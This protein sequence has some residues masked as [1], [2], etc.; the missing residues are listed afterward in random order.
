MRTGLKQFFSYGYREFVMR[1]GLNA[2]ST[3]GA[4]NYMF[5]PGQLRFLMDCVTETAGIPGCY[6]EAGCAYGTTTAFLRK[7]MEESGIKKNYFA[8]DT[9]SGFPS[10][11]TEYEINV[12][13]KSADISF[14][15]S[16]NK[17]EWFDF[18]M[19][20]AGITDV[21]SVQVDIGNFDFDKIAPI[22]FCLLDVDL[23]L[24]IKDCLPRIFRNMPNGG[25]IVV[26][27]CIQDSLYD[28][29][30][31]AYAEFVESHNIT[32]QVVLGKLGFIRRQ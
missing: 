32:E 13:G 26:D 16:T 22:S 1:T 6:V 31:Q 23:Y 7:W 24:P 28:G 3:F 10:N 20:L 29:A 5:T 9:F 12:R 27:D 18:S 15:F 14:P 30:M 25:V 21:T 4:Y 19:S 11:Q 2:Q 8:L 17:K